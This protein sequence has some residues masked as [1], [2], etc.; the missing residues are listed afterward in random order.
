MKRIKVFLKMFKF[1]LIE[2]ILSRDFKIE[3]LEK[4]LK[5]LKETNN[6]SN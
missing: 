3:S 2:E 6:E 4:E 5:Y 1:E